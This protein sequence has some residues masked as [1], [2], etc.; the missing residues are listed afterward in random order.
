MG[1]KLGDDQNLRLNARRM[2]PRSIADDF[3]QSEENRFSLRLSVE[4]VY[5]LVVNATFA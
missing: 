2:R 4:E 3:T 5:M 1:L